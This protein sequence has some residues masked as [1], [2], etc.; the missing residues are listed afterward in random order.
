MSVKGISFDSHTQTTKKRIHCILRVTN[1]PS[2]SGKM[3]PSADEA[4]IIVRVPV[5]PRPRYLF[6]IAP[7]ARRNEVQYKRVLQILALQVAQL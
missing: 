7:A 1:L 4:S 2:I 5:V 6:S 3:R